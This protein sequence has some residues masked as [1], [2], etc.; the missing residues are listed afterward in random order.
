MGTR[1]SFSLS[2]VG[3][4]GHD[5]KLTTHFHLVSTLRRLHGAI[6]PISFVPI[7]AC[8][9]GSFAIVDVLVEDISIDML[10]FIVLSNITRS[11]YSLVYF[12]LVTFFVKLMTGKSISGHSMNID[13][14]TG[15]LISP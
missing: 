2:K 4:T 14:Y 6:L 13:L 5:M 15:V 8:T 3:Q 1:G 9:W 10:P 12:L 11:D 7:A